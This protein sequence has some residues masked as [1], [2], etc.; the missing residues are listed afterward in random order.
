MKTELAGNSLLLGKQTAKAGALREQLAGFNQPALEQEVELEDAL[1]H[2]LS[3]ALRA[4]VQ[5]AA[6]VAKLGEAIAQ[7]TRAESAAAN[8]AVSEADAKAQASQRQDRLA[9]MGEEERPTR[10]LSGGEHFLVSLSL[11]LALSGLEGRNF[12]VDTLFIDEGFGSLDAETLDIATTALESLH[13]R[14]RKVGVIT[15]VAG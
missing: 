5:H 4:A 6:D 15:H 10:S 3:H 2:E 1:G 11:A 8:A 13:S 9:D 14:G 7:V 12:L